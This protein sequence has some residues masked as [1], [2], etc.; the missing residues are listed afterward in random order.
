M[1]RSLGW[2]PLGGVFLIVFCAYGY[3]YQ[4]GGW[5][6]NSR[7][8]LV[9]ANVESGTSRIDPYHR[10]TGDKAC[11]GPEGRCVKAGPGTHFYCDKAPGASWL[12]IPSYAVLYW[13]AGGET[14][15]ADFLEFAA[16]VGSLTSVALPSALAVAALFWLMLIFGISRRRALGL[17][18]GYGLATLAFPYATLFYG[19]QL[20]AALL[21]LG[22]V[23]LVSERKGTLV[24][25]RWG[26]FAAGAALGM[27]VVVEYPSAVPLI[28][29]SVYAATWVRPWQRLAWVAAGIALPGLCCAV[30]HWMVFGGPA[31]LPY[32]YSTQ[33]H[34]SQGFFMGLGVP[35]PHVL[36]ELLVGHYRGLLYSAPWLAAALPGAVLM[37]RHS[38][39]R[40]ELYVSLFIVIFVFWLNSSLVDWQGGWAMG[41][42]YLISAIPFLVIMAS[43]LFLPGAIRSDKLRMLIAAIVL[44]LG[45]HSAHMMLMGAA[46]KPEVPSHIKA[47]YND[48]LRPSFAKGELS[49]STQGIDMPN[50]PRRAE[51]KAWNVGQKVFGLSGRTSLIPLFVLQLLL[52]AWLWRKLRPS[53]SSPPIPTAN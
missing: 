41:P 33:P 36:K 8:D 28:A 13:T 27:S 17:A 2:K 24:L 9:R 25:S 31:T 10:N 38:T 35:E 42:R 32:E 39:H 15:S 1:P 43:G 30:Y 37:F 14:P 51:A 47:P 20:A 21:L 46:V 48:Y 12:A 23:A 11:R 52:L 4:A 6:Q 44:A 40:A 18:L 19:H 50:A 7:F 5:N 3:F 26:L 16:Y 49:I 53:P 29:I 34:R 45:V 22:F